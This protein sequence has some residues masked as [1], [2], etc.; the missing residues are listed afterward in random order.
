[1]WHSCKARGWGVTAGNQTQAAYLG[2]VD[3]VILWIVDITGIVFLS[4]KLNHV[5]TLGSCAQLATNLKVSCCT[6]NKTSLPKIM[7]I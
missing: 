7:E 4:V 1:M 2:A 3:N 6:Y 5:S